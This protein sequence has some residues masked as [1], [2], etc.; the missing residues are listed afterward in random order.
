MPQHINWP[1]CY[2]E[3]LIR[4]HLHTHTHTHAHTHT[5]E[6]Y[7]VKNTIYLMKDLFEITF[8]SDLKCVSSDI[9]NVYLN[10]PMK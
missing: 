4:Y 2:L 7:N 8:D 6:I 1:K 9:T 3:I 10:V 5:H